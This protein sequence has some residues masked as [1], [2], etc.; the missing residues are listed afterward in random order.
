MNKQRGLSLIGVLFVGAIL[1]FL[2]L[3]GLRVVP[4]MTEYLAIKRAISAVAEEASGES[5]VS[6]LRRDFDK[7][8]YVEDVKSVQG[9]DLDITKVNGEIEI[10]AEYS[11]K[12]PLV[13][14]VSLLLE[15]EATSGR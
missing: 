1:G 15:F 3:V 4:A 5:S 10:T 6:D 9:A 13:A 7:R 14:N 11:R 8:A 12:I 2:F